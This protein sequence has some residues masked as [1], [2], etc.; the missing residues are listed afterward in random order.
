MHQSEESLEDQHQSDSLSE[1]SIDN[2]KD[3]NFR[4][5]GYLL[6][7]INFMSD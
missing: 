3:F 2:E 4:P 5:N 6:R 7:K 1:G